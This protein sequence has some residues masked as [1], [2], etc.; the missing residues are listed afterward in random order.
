MATEKQNRKAQEKKSGRDWSQGHAN[1][2]RGENSR[3]ERDPRPTN[4]GSATR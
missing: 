3:Q 2:D 1:V 4:W